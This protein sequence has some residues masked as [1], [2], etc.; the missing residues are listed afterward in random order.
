MKA[1]L[2][3]KTEAVSDDW[4]VQSF[5]LRLLQQNSTLSRQETE[6]HWADA[7]KQN[8]SKPPE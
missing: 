6:N 4:Q 8:K 7:V 3:M 2:Q 1:L 5:S